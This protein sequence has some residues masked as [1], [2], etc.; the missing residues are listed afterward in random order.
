MAKKKSGAKCTP[1]PEYFFVR[2]ICAAAFLGG[3][4]IYHRA[5]VVSLVWWYAVLKDAERYFS[6]FLW[7]DLGRF[8]FSRHLSPKK[9]H[10]H[11][12]D[13]LDGPPFLG[14]RIIIFI[15]RIPASQPFLIEAGARIVTPKCEQSWHFVT[16]MRLRGKNGK[17][18]YIYI[19]STMIRD[20]NKKT[21]FVF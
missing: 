5:V 6:I 15:A 9:E 16:N 12:L 19:M 2:K 3:G 18:V 11:P 17:N 8:I 20:K 21:C 1:P 4:F 10:F 13:A 14:R 7:L